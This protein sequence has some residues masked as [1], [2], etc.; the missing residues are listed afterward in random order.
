M[1]YENDMAYLE[2]LMAS[3]RAKPISSFLLTSGRLAEACDLVHVL[4]VPEDL[5]KMSLSQRVRLQAER[6]WRLFGRDIDIEAEV[7]DDGY[8]H[9]R[10]NKRHVASLGELLIP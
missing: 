1:T 8:F 5:T 3:P 9:V 4:T 7:A 10:G 6:M 2:A